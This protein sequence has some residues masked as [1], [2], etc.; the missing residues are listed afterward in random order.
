MLRG[1]DATAEQRLDSARAAARALLADYPHL[2]TPED[3]AAEGVLDDIAWHRGVTIE[4]GPLGGASARL[5][6]VGGRARIRIS[7]RTRTV[8]RRRFSIAHELGHFELGHG[9]GALAALCSDA[10]GDR[11]APGADEDAANAFAAELLMPEAM[12]APLCERIDLE[13]AARIAARFGCSLEASARRLVEITAIPCA[14][15][16]AEHGMV[17][18][19]RRSRTF[20]A[21]IPTGRRLAAG[22]LAGEHLAR[23]APLADPGVVAATTW[24]PRA[25]ADADL[26]EHS[27][28]LPDRRAT[29]TLLWA[30][31][32]SDHVG[33]RPVRDLDQTGQVTASV[34]GSASLAPRGSGT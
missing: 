18:Y 32:V 22:S 33:A 28:A 19:A 5:A 3:L 4:V 11:H 30:R 16:Y 6:R 21:V 29:L 31:D 34:T 26:V 1:D 8:E 12:I 10:S 2:R 9:A 24:D 7:D 23:G 15:V 13:I 25:D 27:R 14:V 20:A 17:R